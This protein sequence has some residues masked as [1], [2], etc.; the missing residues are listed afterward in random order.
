MISGRG[1]GGPAQKSGRIRPP[2][3]MVKP[4]VGRGGDPNDIEA[5]WQTLKEAMLDIHNKNCSTLA[6]EQLYRASY[7]IVLNKKGDLLYDRVR[8]FETAYFADHVIPAIEKLVTANLISI[9]MGKSNS[10]VNERRQMSE[11]F[12]RNL[13]VSWEDHNTS[14]N[15]VADILMYLDRGYSQDS[16]RPSIYTS[17]IGLYRDRILR[18][19]LNDNADYTIFD[20]LNSVVLDLVNMERDGEVIDRYMIKNSIKM[21]DSLYED[22]NENINQKLYTTTF[23]PV[24]LQSTAAYYAKE[25]QRLLDEGDASVWLPQTERRLSEEVDRCETTLHRD[26]KEQCIKIVEAELISRH[27]DEFLALEASGLKAMLDHN[28]I[29]ELSILF[30]LVA[31]VDETKASMKAILSS[32]VVELGLEI[33]Q[34][35]KN[36]DFSTP[37]PAGDGEEAADGADKSKAPAAPSVSAQQTAAAIK[38]VNDVLQLKD[39]FDNIWRQAFH[40]DL[41]LQTVLTKSFSDFINVFARASEYVSLFIDDNLRRGIRG[42]TDE[43]I[44]V[45]MDKAIILIHYLQDRDMFE[46]YYQKHLAKRLLHSKS[47]SHEAEKEMISRMKS[48]LGNQFTAKFE[49]MLRDMDTSKETTAGYR[50]HIR[51]LGDVER[52]QAELGINILTSNSWP[53]EVMG[54]NAPLAG[55]TECIYPEEITR[56][57][58]SLTKYYLTNRSGRKLS[59]VG[60]AGNA[61]IRCVFPAMAGGKG[62]LAR[63][64]KYEL[65]VST[66]GM[67]IIMLFN[68]LGDRSLTAQ[69]I[70]AQT[71][72]PTPDLMRTLTSLSIAP[73]ARV[74][75]KEPASRRIE[76]TDTFKFNASFVSKTV[77]I[78]APIIN[79]V[80]KVED[81]SERKQTEEKNAQS[82]A[83]IIDAAIVRTMKQRKELGHSQL[84]SEVVTQLVGRFSPEVSVVKKRIEDLIVREYLERVE[85][86][87]VPTYRYLA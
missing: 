2:R 45:I 44:H 43:E 74:L 29:Q 13:R 10:S 70:Q 72:I 49:G 20:I 37:A 39:K 34:N 64:R 81:D 76:M 87:A 86:A 55:G 53:P 22:D 59:W 9:A 56:L 17:C 63:E 67:V 35:V 7:K 5:P 16:R 8:D 66:F 4:M 3:R 46:R 83:H 18:S 42:K 73:K 33:E 69:E 36:T 28:R 21:L 54:R 57:Q 58:E 68:D 75:L 11:H 31:R 71:N 62:P 60:T 25:C 41:V 61:D 24:F 23:E 32:R 65:N 1:G 30:G 19:S 14:M 40:E 82:R 78:K 48:K 52:P 85:D 77:R 50:D 26:T 51:S 84:I 47:E 27:L 80:S 6:F 38:W 12:L 79:A 15:M